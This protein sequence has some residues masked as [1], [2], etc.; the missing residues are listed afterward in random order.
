MVKTSYTKEEIFNLLS[1]IPD[2]EIPVVNIG[3]MGILRDVKL[4]DDGCEIFITPTYTGCPGIAMIENEIIRYVKEIYSGQ[5]YVKL[6]YSPAWTTDWMTV[7]AKEKM[8]K[9][10]IAPPTSSACNKVMS[11]YEYEIVKC[12]HCNSLKTELVS[13]FGSTACKALYK[14]ESCKEPFEYFKCH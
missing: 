2:P 7:E 3:E 9:Y 13:R 14:C 5:V 4:T 10:G 12:P 8:R 6:V 1:L 11:S